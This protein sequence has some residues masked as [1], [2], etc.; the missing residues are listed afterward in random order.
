MSHSFSIGSVAMLLVVGQKSYKGLPRGSYGPLVRAIG[1]HNAF[2]ATLHAQRD[3][4]F[5]WW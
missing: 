3:A 4:W 1:G 5:G 2:H